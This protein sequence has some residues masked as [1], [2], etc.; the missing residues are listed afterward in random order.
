MKVQ[1]L[2]TEPYRAKQHALV[3]RNI[4]ESG[5]EV[6]VSGKVVSLSLSLKPVYIYH[7]LK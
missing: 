5:K 4:D 3:E 7:P 1:N 6:L 2:F